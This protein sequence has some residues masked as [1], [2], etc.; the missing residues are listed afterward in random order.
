VKVRR[1]K[2]LVEL[3]DFEF[4]DSVAKGSSLCLDNAERLFVEAQ[5]ALKAGARR[6]YLI[7]QALSGEEASKT[8]ILVDAVRCPLTKPQ[9]RANQL[10][11]FYDHLSRMI[12]SEACMM[13]PARFHDIEGW[14]EESREEYFLDGSSGFDWIYR[15][16]LLQEREGAVY[17]DYV[18]TDDGRKWETP[19]NAMIEVLTMGGSL[20]P[21][22][23][24]MARHL[25]RA[26]VMSDAGMEVV[27]DIWRS[28]VPDSDT[29]WPALRRKNQDTLDRLDAAGLLGSADADDL[30][31]VL[32]DWQFPLWSLEMRLKEIKFE[33]MRAARESLSARYPESF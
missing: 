26:G 29:A 23:L 1:A 14:I 27:A 13:K 21:A 4:L 11:K 22:S 8:M 17:V 25:G 31:A 32:H 6:G 30:N 18:E 24:S 5:T 16:R 3:T 15:N 2:S 10:A 9:E 28:F 7:L 19:S 20:V 12:Y 33:T